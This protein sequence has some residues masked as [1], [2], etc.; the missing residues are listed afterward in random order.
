M[1]LAAGDLTVFAAQLKWQAIVI[2]LGKPIGPIVAG[3]A[4]AAKVGHMLY[5]KIRLI[6]TMARFTLCPIEL[7]HV[8]AVAVGARKGLPVRQGLMRR[9]CELQAIVRKVLQ[10]HV[11]Q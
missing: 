3:Q 4:I 2:E 1:A 11:R 6:L 7:G 8:L 9:Q 10:R 5:H